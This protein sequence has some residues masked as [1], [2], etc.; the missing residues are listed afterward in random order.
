L[1][2]VDVADRGDL[3]VA[4]REH[5]VHIGPEIV[6]GDGGDGFQRA[7]GRLAIGMVRE[8]GLPPCPRGDAVRIGRLAPQLGNDLR[9]H[10]VDCVGVEARLVEREPQQVDALILAVA[11]HADRAVEIVAGHGEAKLDGVVLDPLLE[12]LGGELAGALIQQSRRQVAD[13]CL[14]GGI[15]AGAAQEGEIERHQ[16]QRRLAHQPGLDAARRHHA[17]DRGRCR[18]LCRRRGRE[19]CRDERNEKPQT[20]DH[21]R[22]SPGCDGLLMR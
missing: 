12:R 18:R 2:S 11:Q 16:R 13:A 3:E 21:D 10:A 14:D 20:P 8:S 6:G 4:A 19:Q 1:P 7:V 22:L 5:A 9:A 15:F 17:F